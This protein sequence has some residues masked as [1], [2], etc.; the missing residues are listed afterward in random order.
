[1]KTWTPNKAKPSSPSAKLEGLLRAFDIGGQLPA[2]GKGKQ[3]HEA[4]IVSG[5]PPE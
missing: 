2:V 4:Q 3:A 5:S 1:M